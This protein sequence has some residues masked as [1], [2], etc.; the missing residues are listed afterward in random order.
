MFLIVVACFI[1][2]FCVCLIKN[3]RYNSVMMTEI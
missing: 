2:L 1:V 3:K